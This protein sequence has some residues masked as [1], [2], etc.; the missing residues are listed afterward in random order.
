M[1]KLIYFFI[2][3]VCILQVIASIPSF[4]IQIYGDIDKELP[5]GTKITFRLNEEYIR[6]STIKNNKYGHEGLFIEKD[7]ILTKE[8]E[9]YAEGDIIEIYIV[10]IKVDE[11]ILNITEDI[12]KTIKISDQDHEKI[13]NLIDEK[14]SD[15][16]PVITEKKDVITEI[17]GI[18]YKKQK[19]SGKKLVELKLEKEKIV[20]L[21]HDFDKSDLSE[22]MIIEIQKE[23]SKKGA[24]IVKNIKLEKDE[25]KSIYVKDISA[26]IDTVC[27]KDME[28]DNIYQISNTCEG[29]NEYLITCPGS[30]E[31]YTCSIEG[32]KYKIDGLRYSAAIEMIPA[33]HSSEPIPAYSGTYGMDSIDHASD[34]SKSGNKQEI[35]CSPNWECSEWSEC[36]DGKK[37]RTC[38]DRSSCGNKEQKP[39]E[40]KECYEEKKTKIKETFKEEPKTSDPINEMPSE[41]LNK[42]QEK[43]KKNILKY[44]IMIFIALIFIGGTG[45]TYY[46]IKKS[47]NYLEKEKKQKM[48]KKES[49]DNLKDYINQTIKEGYPEKEIRKAM[50]DE[51]WSEEIINQAFQNK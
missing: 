32:D 23:G 47:K 50:K 9:G 20:E 36:I 49:L 2:F 33:E 1:K 29:N 46:E 44:I 39:D 12:K 3:L 5:D 45:F 10:G 26:S 48:L 16:Q 15:Y 34:N 30:I 27:I 17:D 42:Y 21:T 35:A 18:S 51:G 41:E 7:N 4:P 14:V 24:T 31:K 43:T 19:I 37:T 22:D 25:T 11:F 13:L 40:Y 28:I 38:I 8:K 6:F